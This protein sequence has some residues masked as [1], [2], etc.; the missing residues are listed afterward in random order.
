VRSAEFAFDAGQETPSQRHVAR[1]TN[2]D[3]ASIFT[4]AHSNKNWWGYA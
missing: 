4:Y 1:S 3:D 2:F